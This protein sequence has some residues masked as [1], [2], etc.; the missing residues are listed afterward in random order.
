MVSNAMVGA[1]QVRAQLFHGL[2]EVEVAQLG[3]ITCS[4]RVASKKLL[5]SVLLRVKA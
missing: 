3:E 5:D 1:P 4:V 2:A